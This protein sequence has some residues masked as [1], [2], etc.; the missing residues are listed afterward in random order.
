MTLVELPF[1]KI[2]L[3]TVEKIVGIEARLVRETSWTVAKVR[4]RNEKNL[5]LYKVATV[6]IMFTITSCLFNIELRL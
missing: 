1:Q 5:F 2:V 6:K 4:R 3:G